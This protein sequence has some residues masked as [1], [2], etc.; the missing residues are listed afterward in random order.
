MDVASNKNRKCGDTD[1]VLQFGGDS[2]RRKLMKKRETESQGKQ[3]G[4]TCRRQVVLAAAPIIR[5]PSFQRQCLPGPW[6]MSS[7]ESP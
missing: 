4:R 5:M 6:P 2:I 1:T 7:S 3:N